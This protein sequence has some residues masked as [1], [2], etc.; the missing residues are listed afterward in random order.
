MKAAHVLMSL[1]IVLHSNSS[2]AD[3]TLPQG[4]E[5]T[6]LDQLRSLF[7][8]TETQLKTASYEAVPALLEPLKTYPLYPYL[9][10]QTHRRFTSR[11]TQTEVNRF[12]DAYPR[13]PRRSALQQTWLNHLA[14]EKRWDDWIVAYQRLPMSSAEYQCDLARAYIATGKE[15][16]G[17]T[18]AT[19]LWTVGK[20]QPDECNPLFD[21]WMKQGHPT[22]DE[23]KA[24]YWLTA[25]SG[26]TSLGRYL[27]RFLDEDTQK[28]ATAYEELL[29]YPAKV[30]NA[31]LN[32]F[33]EA[34]RQKLIKRTFQRKARS[35]L[36]KTAKSWLEFRDQL[37]SDS[38][39][40]ANI[41]LYIGKRLTYSRS[42]DALPLLERIDPEHQYTE[43]TEARL[44]QALGPEEQPIDW[45][46][47]IQL[48][49]TLPKKERASDRWSY[50]YATAVQ[51]LTPDSEAPQKILAGVAKSRSYYGFLAA[52]QLK[53]PFD[54]NNEPFVIN[55][56]MMA[57]LETNPAMQRAREFL[58][59]ERNRSAN[60]EWFSARAS[61][62]QKER[63]HM[64]AIA[65]N[66]GWHHRAIM[67]AIR[68]KQWN[69]LDAR[70]PSLFDELFD[71]K[72][73]KKKIDV[74]WATA[75]AR[76]ESAFKPAAVSHAG[77]RG[78]MQ[79]MPA[80]ARA[81]S[82]KHSIPLPRLDDLF[83]PETNIAL[84]TAYL[85]E[86]YF[87]FDRNRAFASAAY[88]AGPHRV[89]RW[90]KQRGHL[91]LDVWIETI[92]F[93]ETRNYVKNVLAFRVIYGQRAGKD[94]ALLA[95]HEGLLLAHRM[96]AETEAQTCS[97]EC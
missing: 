50:W 12:L 47:V 31:N 94:V 13:F 25:K 45:Q 37:A 27:H 43:L 21:H 48:I 29:R 40:I 72:A 55:L 82:R 22:A 71:E 26:E 8:E 36:E 90:L 89:E 57:A 93:K 30:P 52:D 41:D 7:T 69:Y 35:Q 58:K 60:R 56:D 14:R 70:F 66:W 79:L 96:D 68:H 87:K 9:E 2:T 17:M 61:F 23:A 39:A 10:Y 81:T 95:P 65:A 20:S 24:R 54:L 44:R 46:T 53:Q 32:S 92:P 18:M 28:I 91:P 86:M 33:P 38:P 97:S 75:I 64:A 15:E 4:P 76:Q 6:E 11:L 80:T 16:Q 62:N 49:E 84:G 34:A 88:N 73:N 51:I 42:E 83:K 59:L 3:T 1:L 74:I 77:A 5:T 19:S 63:E 85:S 78:L 67:D